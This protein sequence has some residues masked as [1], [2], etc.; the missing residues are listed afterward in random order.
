MAMFLVEAFPLLSN[1]AHLLAI[2]L[3]NLK[4]LQPRLFIVSLATFKTSRNK[5]NIYVQFIVPAS[6]AAFGRIGFKHRMH[7]AL[8]Y[9]TD[10]NM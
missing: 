7:C 6:V 10:N 8:I 3:T 1:L 9:F 2:R 4:L 5:Y